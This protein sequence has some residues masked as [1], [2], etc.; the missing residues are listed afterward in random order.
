[1]APTASSYDLFLSYNSADHTLVEEIARKM[2]DEHL[3]PFLDRWYLV[4]GARWRPR[5]EQ[6]L[7]SC[8]AVAIFV[9]PGKWVVGSKEKST[10]RLT[11]RPTVQVFR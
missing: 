11:F 2:R 10:L 6:I 3:E 1:M 5:L 8:K 7:S 4:P 9:G